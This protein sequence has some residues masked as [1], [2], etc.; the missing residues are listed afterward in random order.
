MT[1]WRRVTASALIVLGAAF[2]GGGNVAANAA[3]IRL[4]S[5]G[6]LISV[7]KELLAEFEQASG[8]KVAVEFIN[9][10]LANSRIRKGEAAD[11]AIVAPEQAAALVKDGH[12]VAGTPSNIAK[13]GIGLVVRKGAPR[14]DI[15]T[16]DAFK[17]TML[18]A[19][20]VTFN[21]PK[22]GGPVGIYMTALFDRLDI[23][24]AMKPKTKYAA[25]G[26]EGTVEIVGNGEIQYGFSQVSE[27]MNRPTVDLVG[28]L[29][30]KVQ[31]YTNFTATILANS[32][33]PAAARAL[34]A[35]LAGK[36]AAAA[37]K[38]RGLEPG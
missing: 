20:S 7:M 5:P 36:N 27:M 30:E 34:L 29:P 6:S 8:H 23:A 3:E 14:P 10:N 35:F 1:V 33:E 31:F 26:V 16:V 17:A 37:F 13:V 32:K 11:M 21:N 22:S 15:G 19:K 38:S 28:P 24:E 4:L 9:I 12:A 2:A 25:T 18:A